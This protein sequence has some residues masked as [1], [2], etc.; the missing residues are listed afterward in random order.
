[1]LNRTHKTIQGRS[2]KTDKQG[3][4]LIQGEDVGE[5]AHDALNHSCRIRVL[6]MG[7]TKFMQKL[8]SM[9]PF[10]ATSWRIAIKPAN[11][12][13]GKYFSLSCSPFRAL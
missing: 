13:R 12:F 3:W 10:G 2:Y 4:Y 7:H 8:F 6:C 1:M 11:E 9:S 5:H